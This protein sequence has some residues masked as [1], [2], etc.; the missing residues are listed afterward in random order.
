MEGKKKYKRKQNKNNPLKASQLSK[1]QKK[2]I[3]EFGELHPVDV[4]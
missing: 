4:E 3:K 1:G 2:H